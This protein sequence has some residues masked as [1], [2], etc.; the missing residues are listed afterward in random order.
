MPV[1]GNR[2]ARREQIPDF[3]GQRPSPSARPTGKF[4]EP[5]RAGL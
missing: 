1:R 3:T 5:A 2:A 4:I